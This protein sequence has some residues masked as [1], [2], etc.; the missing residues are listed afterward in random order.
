MAGA[1]SN[2]GC[3]TS[4]WRAM[5]STRRY[6]GSSCSKKNW[7]LRSARRG[8]IREGLRRAIDAASARVSVAVLAAGAR[9]ADG[10]RVDLGAA[11]YPALLDEGCGRRLH[12]GWKSSGAV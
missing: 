4:S 12:H 2:E 1:S 11:A 3:T 9:R 7:K 10:D 8:S 6:T 5:A